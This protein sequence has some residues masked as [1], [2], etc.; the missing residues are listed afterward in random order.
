M[1]Q[2]TA[3]TGSPGGTA[4]RGEFLMSGVAHRDLT[5]SSTRTWW[6][7]RFDGIASRR[8]N[9]VGD[10]SPSSNNARLPAAPANSAQR[11]L[12]QVWLSK[13]PQSTLSYLDDQV[14]CEAHPQPL[15]TFA[16]ATVA[17]WSTAL[18]CGVRQLWTPQQLSLVGLRARMTAE[19]MLSATSS[20]VSMTVETACGA[21]SSR[22]C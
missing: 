22:Q 1:D 15:A 20:V 2:C 7:S 9:S 6:A 12:S 16:S 14:A 18:S 4:G 10:A 19:C 8:C 3:R 11:P 21:T 5:F 13:L 17:P